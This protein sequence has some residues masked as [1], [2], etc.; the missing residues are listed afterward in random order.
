VFG[1]QSW[2]CASR[3]SQ[4]V[5]KKLRSQ[6]FETGLSGNA[7]AEIRRAIL[8]AIDVACSE[9]IF[10]SFVINSMSSKFSGNS[11]LAEVS[12]GSR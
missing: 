5:L 11:I 3:Q 9:L 2:S 4:Q 8:S 1:W 10:Y 7:F 6:N 12:T